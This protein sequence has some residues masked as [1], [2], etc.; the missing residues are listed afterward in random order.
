MYCVMLPGVFAKAPQMPRRRLQ[1]SHVELLEEERQAEAKLS[2]YTH[3]ADGQYGID[4][5]NTY[6]VCLIDLFVFDFGEWVKK[7]LFYMLL[8]FYF[9]LLFVC[10]SATVM[11]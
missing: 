8:G 4:M 9:V 5:L 2:G 3:K 7:E 6:L 11:L 10:S 1:W